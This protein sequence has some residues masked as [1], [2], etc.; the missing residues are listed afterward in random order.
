MSNC[1]PISLISPFAK[2]LERLMHSRVTSFF[3]KYNVLYDYQFGFRKGYNTT[4][5]IIDIVNMIETELSSKKYVLGLFLDLKKAF[6]T[7]DINILLYKL[8]YYGIRGHVLN[9]FKSYLLN[10]KQFVHI[11][12]I[13]SSYLDT[14]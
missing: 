10:R 12:G 5:A 2:L 13:S 7:V 3:N 8:H 11:N 6:N 9:W 1:R 4:L 14:T